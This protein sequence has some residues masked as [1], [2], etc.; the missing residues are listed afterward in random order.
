MN[1]SRHGVD[2]F[3]ECIDVGVSK[4][5]VLSVFDQPFWQV[6][7]IGQFGEH[8]HIGA[9]PRL[10]L[11]DDRQLQ[12]LK[13]NFGELDSR[14]DIELTTRQFVDV[15]NMVFDTIGQFLP[16]GIEDLLVHA[17]AIEFH[18]GQNAYQRHLHI[19]EKFV[20]TLLFQFLFENL[21]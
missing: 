3:R 9:R 12:L 1:A 14:I 17:D 15:V 5:R 10:R 20:K 7:K 4:F 2:K 18:F 8:F 16:Q 6:M 21:S 11:L 13:K 19:G